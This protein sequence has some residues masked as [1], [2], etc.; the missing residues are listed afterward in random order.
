MVAALPRDLAASIFVV[1]HVGPYR[2]VLPDIISRSGPLPA[3]HPVQGELVLPGH[4]YI[5]PPDH[6]MLIHRGVI[7]LSRGPRE[8][9][10]R[11]AI[12]PLFRTAARSY[13]PRVMGIVLSGML[14][15]GTA[16]LVEIKRHGGMAIV[17][18]PHEAEYPS[19]PRSALLNAD[20][21]YAIPVTEI[22]EL[23]IRAAK[24][25]DAGSPDA[26]GPDA[27]DAH[28]L[29]A[30][31]INQT[32]K[33]H[34]M[35]GEYSLSPPR[36]LICP[37]CGGT[38]E[39]QDIGALPYYRCHIGHSFSPADMEAA[40][41]KEMERVQEITLRVMVER[42]ALS[43]RLA[44]M[45]GETGDLARAEEWEAAAAEAERRAARMRDLLSESWLRPM[46]HD[47]DG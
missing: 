5:A 42:A 9:R 15:D 3:C 34:A 29:P 8:N 26:G 44:R 25:R 13:G 35:S 21:D 47:G 41:F 37:E 23:L 17:Q 30:A 39:E 38:L 46:P 14:S 32:A 20:V 18:D 12:D 11:P 6:H 16:G 24:G 33:E 4:I 36:L 19:M 43:R 22:A 40:Q 28:T 7:R 1:V 2:S 31:A 10:T 27:G 45:A